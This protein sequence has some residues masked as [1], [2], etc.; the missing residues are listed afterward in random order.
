MIP[1]PGFLPYGADDG[2]VWLRLALTSEAEISS[3]GG[4]AQSGG[5][6]FDPVRGMKCS[7]TPSQGY[8]LTNLAGYEALDI[9]GQVSFEV[10]AGLFAQQDPTNGSSGIDTTSHTQS[11]CCLSA[12]D[13]GNNYIHLGGVTKSA[14][15]K[16]FRFGKATGNHNPNYYE[17]GGGILD[18]VNAGNYVF[19]PGRGDFVT[20]NL[21][22]WGGRVGGGRILAV[23]GM[24]YEKETRND[25]ASQFYRIYIGSL[26]ASSGFQNDLAYMRNLQISTR[27]PVFVCPPI[28]GQL[29]IISDSLFAQDHLT[30]TYKDRVAAGSLR[31]TA[32]QRGF[33][34]GSVSADINGGSGIIADS[35]LGTLAGNVAACLAK[36]PTVVLIQMGTNDTT[37]GASFDADTW[38]TGYKSALTTLLAHPTVQRI[39]VGTVPSMQYNST[40]NTSAHVTAV[41]AANAK[42]NALP[43]WDSRIVVA[44]VFNALGGESPPDNVFIGQFTGANDNLHWHAL[45]HYLAGQEYGRA[46]LRALS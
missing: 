10:E 33:R 18:G 23:D 28:F 7:T 9:E 14:T 25:V 8:L 21:G 46:L 4:V 38:D 43:S 15:A 2:S 41:A 32:H 1:A 20:V 34:F 40:Y 42:V 36:N 16:W 13:P 19:S 27:R 3:A 24:V 37:S 39:V 6:L 11:I 17:F 29:S 44:D 5:A 35:G 12:R 45:G 31:Q 22:W 26:I 30:G